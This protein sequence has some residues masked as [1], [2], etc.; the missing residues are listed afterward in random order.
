MSKKQKKIGMKARNI[1]KVI[2]YQ[3]YKKI[4]HLKPFSKRVLSYQFF[5]MFI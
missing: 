4:E 2:K 3:N 5:P 1:D